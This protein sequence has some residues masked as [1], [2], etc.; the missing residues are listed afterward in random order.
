MSEEKNSGYKKNSEAALR[1][2]E[3]YDWDE[4]LVKLENSYEEF[5]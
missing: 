4:A 3:K 2:A 1:K 5:S